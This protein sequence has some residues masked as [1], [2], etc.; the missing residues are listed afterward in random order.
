[1]KLITLLT[2]VF[3]PACLYN[4]NAQIKIEATPEKWNAV[5]GEATFDNGII[6]VVNTSQKT[7][8]IWFKNS[9]F[10]I[11]SIELDIKGKD[12]TGQSFV[13]IAFHGVNNDHYDGVYFRPFNFRNSE[14][15]EHSV[16]YISSPEYHWD[17]LREKYPGKYEN[18]IQPAPDPNEWFHAKIV[19]DYPHIIVYVNGAEEPSLKVEQISKNKSGKWGLWVD[20]EDGWFKNVTLTATN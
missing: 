12:V 4:L 13:G 5:N 1:M 19:V 6:H 14:R 9:N 11:G 8:L 15:Q 17:V 2:F 10:E 7:A 16:Q 18:D 20:S 3:G